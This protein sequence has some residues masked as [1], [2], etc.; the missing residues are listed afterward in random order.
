M[1]FPV[2]LNDHALIHITER[3]LN[4]WIWFLL[5]EIKLEDTVQMSIGVQLM[6][7]TL[8]W[9]KED[10]LKCVLQGWKVVR[11]SYFIDLLLLAMVPAN[12]NIAFVVTCL[13]LSNLSPSLCLSSYS[14]GFEKLWALP[15]ALWSE[16]VHCAHSIQG[17]SP[18]NQGIFWWSE[19]TAQWMVDQHLLLLHA[20]CYLEML[21]QHRSG[22]LAFKRFCHFFRL[23]KTNHMWKM[24]GPGSW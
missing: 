24:P 16:Q 2:L 22:F 11:T 3:A 9:L 13:D 23:D 19:G 10:I 8:T 20:Q 14:C 17:T 5:H 12:M 6:G 1:R 21:E 7:P 4:T 18:I 15:R